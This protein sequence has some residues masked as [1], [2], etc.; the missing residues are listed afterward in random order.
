MNP[1]SPHPEPKKGKNGDS[2]INLV[3]KFG[4]WPSTVT[5]S[6]LSIIT[7]VLITISIFIWLR[8]PFL[9]YGILAA[10]V[11]PTLIATP[12]A[13]FWFKGLDQ[14]ITMKSELENV[15]SNLALALNEVKE[16]AG[17]LPICANCKKIRDDR[18]YWNQLE[19]FISR[20]SK[21]EFSHG[22][23]PDCALIFFGEYVQPPT[24]GRSFPT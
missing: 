24:D 8:L 3:H 15:N 1:G 22:I 23:C 4:I 17:L 6:F 19:S 13:Y 20:N 16:L 7:S 21:A 14:L 10:I 5:I 18:G 9:S 11:C 12:L 2:M